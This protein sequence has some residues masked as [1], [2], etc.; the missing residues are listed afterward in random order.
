MK[1]TIQIAAAVAFILL[2]SSCVMVRSHADAELQSVVSETLVTST[3]SWNGMPLPAYPEGQPE[4][5]IRRITIP[6][7][8]KLE[9]HQHPV[10]NAG[11]MLSGRLTV[12]TADGKTLHLQAGD[13]IVEV[14]N[15][16][17]YGINPGKTPAEIIVFYA[18]TPGTPVTVL[19]HLNP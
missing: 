4:I 5:S 18:G 3:D 1:S 17:H 15:T 9:M 11:V 13:P 16:A 2:Q 19:E 12:I 6:A 14:V 7:G 10:I 8:T